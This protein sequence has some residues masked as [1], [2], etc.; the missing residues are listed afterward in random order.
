[1]NS[2]GAKMP[3]APPL[4]YEKTV[5]ANFAAHRNGQRSKTQVTGECEAERAVAAAGDSAHGEYAQADHRQRTRHQAADRGLHPLRHS[6]KTPEQSAQLEQ[7]IREGDR[8][9][10][11]QH[12]EQRVK[13][14]R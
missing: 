12:P 7:P 14:Q 8:D 3:P 4:E 6:A 2:A 10:R 1:M 9:E 5:A 11:G 13:A